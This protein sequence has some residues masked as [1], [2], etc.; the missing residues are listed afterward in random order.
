MP[1]RRGASPTQRTMNALRKQGYEP[2][3]VERRNPKIKWKT[4]DLYGIIDLIAVRPLVV[5]GVQA[6]S[7]TNVG[8]RVK[9]AM[10]E[11]RLLQW[12]ASGARFEVWGWRKIKAT[13]RWEPKVVS[14]WLDE[15][16][17]LRWGVVEQEP[18]EI[19]DGAD[20]SL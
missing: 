12:L 9:K 7:A 19:D 16:L 6:T 5:L 8:A 18:E 13:G 4:H 3:I 2:G 17:E 10:A 20:G 15:E 1:K 11:P 14:F